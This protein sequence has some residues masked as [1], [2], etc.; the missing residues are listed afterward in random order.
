MTRL[1]GSALPFADQTFRFR[2]IGSFLVSGQFS[3]PGGTPF[4]ALLTLVLMS[5]FLSEAEGL[6]SLLNGRRVSKIVVLV[7]C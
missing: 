5:R 2:M 6:L 4:K 1:A 3:P 7:S